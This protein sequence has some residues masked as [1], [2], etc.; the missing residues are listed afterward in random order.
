[1]HSKTGYAHTIDEGNYIQRWALLISHY[2]LY[3]DGKFCISGWRLNV[4][5]Y[6][7][8]LIYLNIL[9]YV[10]RITTLGCIYVSIWKRYHYKNKILIWLLNK[11]KVQQHFIVFILFLID[12]TTVLCVQHTLF[13]TRY[14]LRSICKIKSCLFKKIE[15]FLDL[16]NIWNRWIGWMHIIPNIKLIYILS[17][18]LAFSYADSKPYSDH[19]RS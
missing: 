18:V 1:M 10:C 14:A 7:I 17:I 9:Y 3:Y 2:S 16:F 4:N 12:R 11:N 8:I 13:Y 5:T 15:M 19:S 6:D